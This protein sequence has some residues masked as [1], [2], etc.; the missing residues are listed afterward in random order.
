MTRSFN[1]TNSLSFFIKKCV[2]THYNAEITLE[3]LF[4]IFR[5][6]LFNKQKLRWPERAYFLIRNQ[7]PLLFYKLL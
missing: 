7:K 1:P 6:H 4:L 3:A 5:I 2:S